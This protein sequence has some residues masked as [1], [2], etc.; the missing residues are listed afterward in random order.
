MTTP[1]DDLRARF[2]GAADSIDAG[3]LSLDEVRATARRRTLWTRAG[4]V[5]G[6]LGLVAAGVVAVVATNSSDD[7]GTLVSADPTVPESTVA[8]EDTI[9]STLPES[10]T[11]SV[12]VEVIQRAGVVG[13]P[14][15]LG[16]A[17]EYGEWVVPWRDG[18]LV[19][20]QVYQPQPLPPELPEEIVALFPPEV[21]ELFDGQ[22]PPTISEA[23]DMLSE[24]GLL[25]VVADIIAANPEASDAI[26]S[27]PVD[28]E[29]TL[30]VRFTT[31]GVSWEP[32]EMTTPPG[33][34]FLSGLTAVG[35]RLA[36]AYSTID[37]LTGMNLDGI[38]RVASTA[39]L[40]TWDVQE[41]TV[42]PPPVAFPGGINWS[43]DV[44]GF[45]ANE[46]GW[47]L[48]AFGG[49]QVD[50]A[51]LLP[52]EVR[53]EL[54]GVDDEVGYGMYHDD[55]G[56]VV[57]RNVGEV[58]ETDVYTWEELGVAAEVVPYL[59]GDRYYE[60]TRWSSTWG[61]A[62][63]QAGGVT[64]FGQLVATS[65]GFLQVGEDVQF[66]PD[67][68]AWTPVELPLGDRS[69]TGAFAFDGGA[70]L[71]AS[72]FQ[73]RG[74]EFH[75]VDATGGSPVLLDLPGL[76]EYTQSGYSPS[77][78]HV[79]VLDAGEPP[80]PTPPFVVEHEGYRLTLAAS[81]EGVEIVE[82]ATG[83]VVGTADIADF[84]QQTDGNV[85]LDDTGVTVTDPVTGELVVMIPAEVLDAASDEQSKEYSYEYAP[86]FWLLASGDGERFLL[87]DL[88]DGPEGN[89]VGIM[90]I[91]SNGTKVLAQ[92]DDQWVVYDL[93]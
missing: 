62:P 5:V 90:G 14:A 87:V 23:T 60:P 39:D 12:T 7:P 32:V 81:M 31:D 89:F 13:Q 93:P 40:V 57:E 36:V 49:A 2:H 47:V 25:D 22:L 1:D 78:R 19:G 50:V 66:S 92:F 64:G 54:A 74:A 56:V 65:A 79:L 20:T 9:A 33:A 70:V 55:R 43:A 59:R 10:T 83:D 68:I 75:R 35:D 8:V 88:D 63:T 42:P 91:A 58:T 24:A 67:G 61:G 73:S 15:G 76:P 77:T 84:G 38:I 11:P 72:D 51:A 29:P 28:D 26:Y 34:S 6:V 4:A 45:A 41:V 85:M 16:G 46:S 48:A 80:P 27:A 37:P 21:V 44:V 30:D 53:I 69:V 86:D 17:P 71:V 52:P 3:D 18:F 82:I